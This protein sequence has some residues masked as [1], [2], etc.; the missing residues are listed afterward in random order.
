MKVLSKEEKEELV[1]QEQK[2]EKKEPANGKTYSVEKVREMHKDAYKH[3][4]QALD[5]ELTIMYCEGIN[6]RDMAKHFRRTNGAIWSRIK[7]LELEE[8]YG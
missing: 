4:T 2:A 7:K 1:V 3:W 6:V 5:E 8:L